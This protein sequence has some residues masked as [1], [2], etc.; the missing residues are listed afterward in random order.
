MSKKLTRKAVAAVMAITLIGSGMYAPAVNNILMNSGITA[1]AID[2]PEDGSKD[3]NYPLKTEFDIDTG[4]LSISGVIKKTSSIQNFKSRGV[5]KVVFTDATWFP[6][7]SSNLFRDFLN[8][9]EIDLTNVNT[10]RTTNMA[11]LFS[12]CTYLKSIN[13]ADIDTSKVTT[14]HSMFNDCAKL[15]SIDLSRFDTSNVTSMIHM[16]CGCSSLTSIDLS[17]FDTRNVTDMKG[18]FAGCSGLTSLDLSGLKNCNVHDMSN[19]FSGCKGLTSLDLSNL[20]TSDVVLFYNMFGSCSGLTSLDLSSFD[21]SGATNMANMFSECTGLTSLDLSSWDTSNVKTVSEI[22]KGCNNL[23]TVDMS[24][25]NTQNVETVSSMF[26]SCSK[27]TSV[28]LSNFDTSKVTYSSEIFAYCT[29]LASVDLSGW[30]TSNFKD[31]S[32]MFYNCSSLESLDVSH[33]NTE[34]VND[35]NYMFYNCD[36]LSDLDLTNFTV[37]KNTKTTRML[38]SCDLLADEIVKVTSNS[39]SLDGMIG[40]NFY[41]TPCA[42]LNKLVLDGPEGEM[43]VNDFSA[44]PM[45]NDSYQITYY[46]SAP[47]IDK[48]ITLK[49]YDKND[50]RLIES[51]NTYGLIDHCQSVY[52]V[53]TYVDQYKNRASGQP[54]VN[55][56]KA[57][58]TY[59]TAADEYFHHTLPSYTAPVLNDDDMNIIESKKMIDETDSCK[60]SLV[61]NSGTSIRIYYTGDE[62]TAKVGSA[63][64]TAKE[65]K[66]GKYFEIPDVAAHTL[67]KDFTITIGDKNVTF[68]AISYVQRI[69]EN[70]NSN[71]DNLSKALYNYSKAANEYKQS[72]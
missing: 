33:F 70:K 50:R 61:L 47:D 62:N 39:L 44:L 7:D 20:N 48:E 30:N 5:K 72:N 42:K 49:A 40:V 10:S 66:N 57:L 15:E 9:E 56:V 34:K 6:E 25:W 60:I 69:I 14:M 51:N 53:R 37:R 54:L 43:T 38:D 46:V 13:F 71:L 19:M 59:C 67:S 16:F 18:M 45:N 8:L 68:S 26:N 64:L 65:N 28:D 12:G 21:T 36:K 31:M 32:K 63:V 3:Y 41:V 22:F 1:N 17:K 58:D 2:L 11:S 29:D 35:M 52:S 23:E 55:L 24:N 4:V 27:L